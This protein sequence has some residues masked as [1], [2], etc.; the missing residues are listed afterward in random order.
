MMIIFT[1]RVYDLPRNYLSHVIKRVAHA[2]DAINNMTPN[3]IVDNVYLGS[4]DDATN[5]AVLKRLNIGL[6]I[7]I[8]SQYEL[9]RLRLP[10]HDIK[11]VRFVA[12][13]TPE[14]PMNNHMIDAYIT[15]RQYQ[16]K[17]P[18]KNILVHCKAGISRSATLVIAYIMIRYCV[19]L[20]NALTLTTKKRKIVYP[21]RGFLYQLKQG[22]KMLLCEW[23]NSPLT[24]H[25][26][27]TPPSA[28]REV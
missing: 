5:A 28:T 9:R 19:T 4:A 23:G 2:T 14:T 21:N 11:H 18:D 24:R 6:V 12:D 15:M 20:K 16:E 7:S 8:M 1:L 27:P 17:F 25:R 13:D 26:S 3:L 10:I 22:E